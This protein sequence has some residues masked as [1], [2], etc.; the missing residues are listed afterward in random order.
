MSDTIAVSN[1]S[2][3]CETEHA[4][5]QTQSVMSK[6]LGIAMKPSSLSVLDQGIVS[7][8][9]LAT[10]V[11][12]GRLC[13][14]EGYGSYVLAMTVAIVGTGILCELVT[15]PFTV[16]GQRRSNGSLARYTGSAIVHQFIA[17]V[18]VLA[19][20]LGVIAACG[21]LG[22][23]WSL[24]PVAAV[25]LPFIVSREFVR[26]MSF[27]RFQFRVALAVDVTVSVLQLGGLAFLWAT[28]RLTAATA[29]ASLG[30]ACAA[31]VTVWLVATSREIEISKPHLKLHAVRNWR[32]GRWTLLAYLVGSTTP[33][34]MPWVLAGFHSNEATGRLAAANALIGLSYMFVSGISNWL[35]AAA[36]REYRKHGSAALRSCLG[37]TMAILAAVLVPFLAFVWFGGEWLVHFVFGDDFTGLGLVSFVI[38]A[39][40]LVNA[41]NIVTGNG[42]WAVDRPQDGLTADAATLIVTVALAVIFVPGLSELGAALAMAGGQLTGALLRSTILLRVL[43]ENERERTDETAKETA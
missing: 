12:L 39:G 3:G 38:A 8:T 31:V 30:V 10:G 9:N 23:L 37:R 1:A 5:P 6:L 34:I 43:A 2:L 15:N 36:A 26:Q 35:T 11:L 33:F 22:K 41:V 42:L 17:T 24:L 4:L 16:Y 28:G 27:A 20:I 19:M 32:F 40:V 25:A 14:A 18:V 21:Q 7:A 29:L 13:E